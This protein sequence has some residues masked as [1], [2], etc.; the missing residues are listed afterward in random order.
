M[1][2]LYGVVVVAQ[3]YC[4]KYIVKGGNMKE[5]W[6]SSEFEQLPKSLI[7]EVMRSSL[8]QPTVS[9]LSSSS[10]ASQSSENREGE[11]YS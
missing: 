6:L 7:L 11:C 4:M 1:M 3:E 9:S 2:L 10:S 8:T 5:I